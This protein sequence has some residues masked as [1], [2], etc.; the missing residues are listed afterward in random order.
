MAPL[1]MKMII[2][3]AT[4]AVIEPTDRSS[5]PAEMTKV[6]PTA[7]MAMKALRVATL[8]RLP[9][10]QEVVVGEG[11]REKQQGQR[12]ERRQRRHVDATA[13]IQTRSRLACSVGHSAPVSMPI[14][15][16]SPVTPVA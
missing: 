12:Q 6:P 2:R 8:T 14:A 7:T 10:G 1:F 15:A 16:C 9:H 13:E 11:A 5:P 3:L 4:K